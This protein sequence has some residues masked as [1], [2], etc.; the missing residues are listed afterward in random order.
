[1][2][3]VRL[4]CFALPGEEVLGCCPQRP[5]VF[6]AIPRCFREDLKHVSRRDTKQQHVLMG[7]L[8]CEVRIAEK[9]KMMNRIGFLGELRGNGSSA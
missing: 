8:L 2:L 1:M 9:T 7:S 6:R 5:M 4:C 3:V